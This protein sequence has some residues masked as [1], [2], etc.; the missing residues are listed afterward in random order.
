[1]YTVVLSQTTQMLP[2]NSLR[3]P[4]ENPILG[5]DSTLTFFCPVNKK[6]IQ[7]AKADV[8]NPAAITVGDSVYVLSRSQDNAGT[9]RVGLASSSDGIH[10]KMLKEPVYIRRPEFFKRMI[11]PGDVR[12]RA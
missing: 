3:K 2:F 6:V 11:I 8:Y 4:A 9:S 12:T 10:F 5:R 1:M 7:W